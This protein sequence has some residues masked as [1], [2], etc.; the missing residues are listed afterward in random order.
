MPSTGVIID[1]KAF[2]VDAASDGQSA[3]GQRGREVRA[4]SGANLEIAL[5]KASF[6]PERD[7]ACACTKGWTSAHAS[8][9]N[10]PRLA[11]ASDPKSRHAPRAVW[12]SDGHDCNQATAALA[13]PRAS[14]DG[15]GQPA[16]AFDTPGAA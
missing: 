10:A 14:W 6:P 13:A 16:K 5:V 12:G 8:P 11:E 4:S 9:A 7:W 15:D 1:E 3:I 2:D